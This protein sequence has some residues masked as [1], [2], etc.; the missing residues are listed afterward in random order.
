MA[1][2]ISLKDRLDELKDRW[3]LT[4]PAYFMVLCTHQIEITTGMKCGIAC[5]G[6]FI[7]LNEKFFE[8]KSDRYLD[9]AMKIEIIRILLKHP[10]QRQLPNRVKMYISSNLVIANNMKLNEI[11]LK[12][13]RDVFHSYEYDRECLEVI[14]DNL[15][16]PEQCSNQGQGNGNNKSNSN[17][18]NSAQGQ[19]KGQKG[20]NEQ[21]NGQGNNSGNG[22]DE[23]DENGSGNNNENDPLNNFD[24]GCSSTEDAYERSQFWKEDDYRNVEINNIID[25]IDS[26]RSWGTVPGNVIDVIKK[27]L[28]PKFN[29]KAL[30]QQFRSTVVSSDYDK[31]RMKPSRRFGYEAMGSKR[32][33]TTSLLVA[34]D[35]SGS[36]SD[37]ELE[38]ALGFIQGFFKYAVNKLDIVQFDTQI[39]PDS[40]ITIDKRPKQWKVHGRGGTDFDPVFDFVQNKSKSHYDG[41]LIVTDGYASVPESKY[42]KSNYKHTR[43]LWVLN[44]EQNWKHFKDN[45]GFAKFGKCTYV[46]KASNS[47]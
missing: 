45:T 44:N 36:I 22:E 31:T 34:V 32:K 16:I 28:E 10:Y 20:Q 14:Y 30:F 6:G 9:E 25:K 3:F 46:D 12:T 26:S 21:G 47:K 27:S 15:N 38:L 33:N 37:D 35:T 11:H 42:L 24:G 1:D 8:D 13:T 29:Y 19:G 5:G 17:G 7:Y 2:K 43:Y 18:N 23:N 41:V 40:L 4:E 39:Y